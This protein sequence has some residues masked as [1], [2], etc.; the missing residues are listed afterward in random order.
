[1]ISIRS[2]RLGSRL[3]I[4]LLSTHLRR[5]PAIARALI[6]GLALAAAAAI[7]VGGAAQAGLTAVL[8]AQ[9]SILPANV[10]IGIG[11]NAAVTLAFEHEMDRSSV[12]ASLTITPARDLRL[13]WS[14]DRRT[15]RVAPAGLWATDQ[16]YLL[17]VGTS[18]RAA[19]GALLAAPARYS[20]TTQTAPRVD[21]FSVR[22][23]AELPGGSRALHAAGDD[24]DLL[25]PDLTSGVSAE[26]ALRIA[27][28]APMNRG[29]VEAAFLLSPAVP[30]IFS[31]TA[32][33][34][35]FT[36]IER[37]APDA[38]YAVSL[39]G[40]HDL[41][42][43]PLAGDASFSFTTL[44]AAQLVQS[45]PVAGAT[46]VS[47]KEIV[48]WFSQPVDSAAVGA[49][50]RVSDGTTGKALTG[51][52]VWNATA[53]QL[54]FTPTRAFAAGHR[55]D[56]SL[57]D[58][59]IDADGNAMTASLTFTTR[60]SSRRAIAGPAPSAT[61]VEYAF[62][63]LNAARAAYGLKPLVYSGAIES[64]ALAHAWE[65]V[66]YN[67]FSHTGRDGSSH[68]D[69]LRRA[70]LVFGWNGENACMNNSTGRT[71]TQTLDWCQGQFM[72]EPYPGVANHIGNILSTHY[73]KVGIGIAI[74]GA[75]VI[76]VWDFTD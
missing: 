36:P 10:G 22:F 45:S 75:K 40:V 28:N 66:N 11:T 7:S 33:T 8:P 76:V 24:P 49:A 55:I 20:F 17:V 71:P 63:Q 61:L 57:A 29:E 39:A 12:E 70:G 34:V 51:S 42:G 9:V 23:V 58:G 30:G 27:F 60:A 26:T 2:G 25:A 38:R 59:A 54:R 52:I 56:L 3:P 64:V 67:Y 47:A 5:H 35:T 65:Q 68:E 62:N 48:L 16:R 41:T 50:L 46:R 53:T 73:T 21:E 15:L 43:N 1:M 72:S 13:A 31:W 44:A 37:L 19:S 14:N 4:A 69:R 6:V 32:S 74:K 18:A